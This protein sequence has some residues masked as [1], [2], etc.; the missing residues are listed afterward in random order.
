[1]KAK[2][3]YH[4]HWCIDSQVIT[5][6]ITAAE[7]QKN[8]VILEIG[9]GQG[10]LTQELAKTCKKVIAVEIDLDLKKI[11]T[12]PKNVELIFGNALDILQERDDFTKIISNLP[13]QLAEPLFQYLCVH[14]KLSV[15]TLPK[16][17]S[18]LAQTHPIFS[19]FLNVEL[20]QDVLRES[21]DPPPKVQSVIV[22][23]TKNTQ[24]TDDL[25]IRRK[26]YLQR[27]KKLKNGLRDTL[28]DYAKRKGKS[29][30]K[31]KAEELIFAMKLEG[32][33]LDY[34]IK[35]MPVQLY[36][37]IAQQCVSL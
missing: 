14:P 30:T 13:Y 8:D 2:Q 29:L 10:I 5:A 36:T 4:Q 22:R 26:L 6:L 12:L 35:V 31:K 16:K 18:Q 3:Q 19:A 25:F 27:G 20:V 28:I 34:L 1:M 33:W 7:I 24:D 15:L 9:P 23:V 37:Q 21:F 11:I 17:F 32:K